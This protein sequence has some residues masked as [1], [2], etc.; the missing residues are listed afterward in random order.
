M[1]CQELST[2]LSERP[3]AALP[4]DLRTQAEQHLATC[5]GCRSLTQ[6]IDG[7]Q[8]M[9]VPQ[10]VFSPE[11]IAPVRPMP[12][13]GLFIAFAFA[14]P[15]LLAGLGVWWKG[16]YGWAVLPTDSAVLFAILSAIGLG[17]LALG[18]YRQFKPG[19]K[20]TIDGLA[21]VMILLAGFVVFAAVE[22][23]WHPAESALALPSAWRCMRFGTIV[24]LG[25]SLALLSWARL[26]FASNSWSASFWTGALASMAGIIALGVHCPNLELSHI[27]LGHASV[28]LVASGLIAW[29]AR[30]FFG[31]R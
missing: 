21:A 2:L 6:M 13:R 28:I 15:I 27:L 25:T 26:G 10:S 4:A 7:I 20:G 19:A 9:P 3:L 18:F 8:R 12:S 14:A 31:L 1:T 5:P 29:M 17:A 11:K 23:G 16:A 22:F 24:A 30:R